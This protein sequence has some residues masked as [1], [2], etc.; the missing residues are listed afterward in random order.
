MPRRLRPWAS[1]APAGHAAIDQLLRAILRSEAQTLHHAGAEPLDQ[2]IG[3]SD[4]RPRR[5]D[6]FGGFQVQHHRTLAA[7]VDVRRVRRGGFAVDR[8]DIRPKIGQ[9]LPGKRRG[10]QPR[11]L[12][13]P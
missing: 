2:H 9:Q 10:P 7:P 6:A 8:N 13:H 5:R 11:K 3:G 4:Q 1:L 12:H